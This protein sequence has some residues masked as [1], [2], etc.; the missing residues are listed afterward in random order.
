[1]PTKE[2]TVI[3]AE[4]M[5]GPESIRPVVMMKAR[6]GLWIPGSGLWPAPE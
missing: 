2:F 1:M 4:R 3:P 5:R 6:Q